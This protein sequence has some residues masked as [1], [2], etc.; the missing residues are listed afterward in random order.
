[1]SH[2]FLQL[3]AIF[4]SWFS[5]LLVTYFA[6]RWFCYQG[7]SW[8]KVSSWVFS[9]F[10]GIILTIVMY[11]IVPERYQDMF[12]V[13]AHQLAC[14]AIV[15]LLLLRIDAYVRLTSVVFISDIKLYGAIITLYFLMG[16]NSLV[17]IILDSHTIVEL[18]HLA[19]SYI[20]RASILLCLVLEMKMRYI[21]AHQTARHTDITS[22]N[23]ADDYLD[24]L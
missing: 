17:I 16:F 21:L 2:F 3:S 1:M 14:A 4:V 6:V 12:N 13:I 9:I 24:S 19:I 22:N 11:Y 18:S 7:M 10:I 15:H 23:H 8:Q 5:V 20:T